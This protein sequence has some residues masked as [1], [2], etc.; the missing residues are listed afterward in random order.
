MLGRQYMPT[1]AWYPAVLIIG[2]SVVPS[3]CITLPLCAPGQ[4]FGLLRAGGP[5]KP[6][7]HCWVSGKLC[8]QLRQ[9]CSQQADW[10]RQQWWL[11]TH[12]LSGMPHSR[13]SLVCSQL[14][15]RRH[16][17]WAQGMRHFLGAL[18]NLACR[19]DAKTGGPAEDAELQ[20]S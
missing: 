20:M 4:H 17:C 13:H 19:C 14:T 15:V 3:R 2:A 5:S 8:E 9:E 16:K 18:E 10:R 7:F 6:D 11:G 1:S 12:E